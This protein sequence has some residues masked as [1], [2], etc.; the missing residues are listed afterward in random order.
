MNQG[1]L[2][3]NALIAAVRRNGV[4]QSVFPVTDAQSSITYDVFGI[5]NADRM[6]LTNKAPTRNFDP[7]VQ[8]NAA[9]VHSPCVM[10]VD[11]PGAIKLFVSETES[12]V[13]CP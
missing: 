1:I 10:V 2:R 7:I 6:A 13:D 8:V 4:V 9:L 3:Y 11:S 12:G 5:D